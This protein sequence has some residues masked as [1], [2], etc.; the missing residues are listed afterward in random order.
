MNSI[1]FL[2]LSVFMISS[3]F[4]V[5]FVTNVEASN[6]P[7][8]KMVDNYLNIDP[9]WNG[10]IQTRVETRTGGWARGVGL[11]SWDRPFR[12]SVWLIHATSTLQETEI[13]GT[14]NVGISQTIVNSHWYGNLWVQARAN[15]TSIP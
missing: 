7:Q 9:L 3:F 14:R 4:F 12:A 6:A 2:I 11:F 13:P 1:K 15:M 10:T 8:E 5:P